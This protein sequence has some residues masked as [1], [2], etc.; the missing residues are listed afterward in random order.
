MSGDRSA[1]NDTLDD[2]H[3]ET[4]GSIDENV[5]FSRRPL[6]DKFQ[7]PILDVDMVK[8]YQKAYD[9]ITMTNFNTTRSKG[10]NNKAFRN[11]SMAHESA[12]QEAIAKQQKRQI[13]KEMEECTFQPHLTSRHSTSRHRHNKKRK[14]SQFLKDQK[15]WD[16]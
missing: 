10:G 6:S 11:R 8:E 15:Q 7:V 5:A 14:I 4:C 1:A 13:E 12:R 16:K 3:L 9:S 2:P